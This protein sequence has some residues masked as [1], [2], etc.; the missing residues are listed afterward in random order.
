MKKHL[1]ILLLLCCGTVVSAQNPDELSKARKKQVADSIKLFKK[2]K[3]D[4]IKLSNQVYPKADIQPTFPGGDNGLQRFLADN[5]Q[6]PTRDREGNTQGKVVVRFIVEKDGSLSHIEALH[7]P[8]TTMGMEAER[9]V[10]VMPRW[11]PGILNGRIVRVQF[12]I[13]VPFTLRP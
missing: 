13:E 3:A 2:N 4:S 9:L 8:T 11:K 7:M 12:A 1:V 10:K 5:L 6:Y